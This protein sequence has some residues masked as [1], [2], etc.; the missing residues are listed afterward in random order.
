M[1]AIPQLRCLDISMFVSS[2][3]KPT[4]TPSCVCVNSHVCVCVCENQ[5]STSDDV[6]ITFHFIFWDNWT[7]C[8][9]VWPASPGVCLCPP[10]PSA[11]VAG[12]HY[13]T[14]LLHGWE[15]SE[16]RLSWLYSKHFICCPLP[17]PWICSQLW[18]CYPLYLFIFKLVYKIFSPDLA[19]SSIIFF[20]KIPSLL[21]WLY[22][23]PSYL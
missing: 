22:P 23:V 12:T 2:W 1:L 18:S 17:Q 11:Q 13:H 9:P 3:E 6:Y 8:S 19:F 20:L 21:L 14:L 4:C 10:I 15:E 7:W 16:L 5:K